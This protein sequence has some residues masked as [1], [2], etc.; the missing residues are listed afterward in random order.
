MRGLATLGHLMRGHD[1]LSD[2]TVRRAF[3]PRVA[4]AL[5]FALLLAACSVSA[6]ASGGGANPPPSISPTPNYLNVCAPVGADTS[7]PCLRTT[8]Q[9]IDAARAKEGIRP[10]LLPADFSRL[11]VPEQLFVAVN[12]ER[13][14]RGL[15]PFTGLAAVLDAKAQR[16]AD[17]LQLPPRPGRSWSSVGTEWIRCSR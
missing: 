2:T 6:E 3:P 15:A 7:L 5:G 12:R 4:A 13:V 11:T 16:G 17:T 1:H 8:L 10:M 9:A 14:D